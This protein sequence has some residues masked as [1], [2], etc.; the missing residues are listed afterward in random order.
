MNLEHFKVIAAGKY[1]T[2]VVFGRPIGDSETKINIFVQIGLLN[3]YWKNI[4]LRTLLDAF[5]S[6]NYYL[7]VF[8]KP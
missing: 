7:S 6:C 3:M 2:I 8:G 4:L 1:N 5:F